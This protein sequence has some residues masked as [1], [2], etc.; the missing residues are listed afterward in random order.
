M[1][2]NRIRS[3]DACQHVDFRSMSNTESALRI[4]MDVSGVVKSRLDAPDGISFTEFTY[5]LLQGYDF[6]HLHRTRGVSIQIGGSDQWGNII[7]GI[8]LIRK[9]DAPV[10]P[11]PG[12]EGAVTTGVDAEAAVEEDVAYGL[13]FPLVTTASGEKFGKSAGNAIWMDQDMCSVFDFYQFFRRTPD[14]EVKR[15][16]KYFTFMAEEEVDALMAR[17]EASPESHFP[18]RT[19]AYE[20]THLVHGS[21]NAKRSEIKSRLLYDTDRGSDQLSVSDI[22]DAFEGDNRLVRLPRDQVVGKTVAEVAARSGSVKSVSAARKLVSSGGLYLNN[23]K[24]VDETEKVDLS[25]HAME[26]SVLLL[27][28]GKSK[29][30]IV[31][32]E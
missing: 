11:M 21:E 26:D 16:L 23:V 10:G 15:Y 22:L 25:V 32:I 14:S 2:A 30:T 1:R 31:N 17:H 3:R 6:Q 12:S 20:V 19:L 4:E 24:V 29:Y 13:T 9:M 18:Q 8:E 7:S 5:Q 27:R 28:A